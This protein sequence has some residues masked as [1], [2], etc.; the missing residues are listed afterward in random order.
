MYSARSVGQVEEVASNL[1]S[2]IG[3]PGRSVSSKHV[4]LF[5]WTA[6]GDNGADGHLALRHAEE[7][8]RFQEGGF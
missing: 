7:V 4:F 5:Q 3:D 6:N 8:S 2:C 1:R